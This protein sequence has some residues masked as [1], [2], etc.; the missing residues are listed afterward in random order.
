MSCLSGPWAHV[1]ATLKRHHGCHTDQGF[2]RRATL[3]SP[4]LLRET[5]ETIAAVPLFAVTPL[6]RPWHTRWGASREELRSAMPGDEL[7]PKAQFQAT[8]AITIAAPASAVYPWLLQ[9]GFGRAGFYSYDLLDSLGRAS[10]ERIVPELQQVRV[11][12]WVPMSPTPTETTAFK[13]DSFEAPN[14]M[15]WRKPDSTW[16]WRLEAVDGGTRLVTRL[17]VVYNWK[18]PFAAAFSV[19]LIEFGDFAMMRRMLKGIRRRA[20]NGAHAAEA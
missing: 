19:W 20:V 3:N 9:V 10:A 12:D 1:P 2:H 4:R 17:R 18:K 11:G 13:V 14:W 6:L 7:L 16:S 5:L 15:L 8:R